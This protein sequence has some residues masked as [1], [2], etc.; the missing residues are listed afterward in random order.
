MKKK[1]LLGCG[2]PLALIVAAAIFAAR[3]I[4][5]PAKAQRTETVTRGDV[6]IKVVE[7]GSIEPLTKVEVKSKVAGR[8]LQLMADEGQMVMQGQ[9]IALIDTLE[10]DNQVAAL[11]AQM[12]GAQ[13]R[14]ASATKAT[15]FQRLQTSTGINQFEEAVRSAQA[16]VDLLTT[17]AAAQPTLTSKSIAIA[18]ANLDAANAQL[19]STRADL[20]VQEQNLRLL[21]ETTQPQARVNAQTNVDR[22][23]A[24][25]RNA[26]RNVERQKMLLEKGFVSQQVVDNAQTELDVQNAL[27]QDA[28]DRLARLP[29]SQQLERANAESQVARA[30][31]QVASAE[32]QVRQNTAALEQAQT[33]TLPQTKQQELAGARAALAQAKAQLQAARSNQVQDRMRGD[34]ADASRA[35]VKQLEKQLAELVVRQKDATIYAPMSGIITKRYLEKGEMVTSAVSSFSS[36]NPIFQISDRAVRLVKLNINEVDVDKLKVGTPAEIRI[37]AL[38]DTV[39]TGRVRKVAPA[40]AGATS[41]VGGTGVNTSSSQSVIR[42]LVEVQVDQKDLRLKPGLSARCSIIIARSRNTLRVPKNCVETQNGTDTVKVVTPSP[43]PDKPEVETSRT[44]KVGL[45]GDDFAEILEGL[46]EGEKIRPAEFKGPARQTIEMRG[47]P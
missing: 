26:E 46:K 16:R 5:S 38:R 8:V 17:E 31:S 22:A 35:Q 15:E 39:F 40:S 10:V 4:K 18:K 42:F 45:R 34:D 12:E 43:A 13:A 21:V 30:K 25:K 32:S 44:V 19:E 33:S 6:E 3:S 36:G 28:K 41:A 27:L 2:I 37:D 47:G 20:K 23:A 29:Q 9:P 24:Q 14:L 11:R 7:T 1:I